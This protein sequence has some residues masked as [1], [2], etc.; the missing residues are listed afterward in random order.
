MR[1]C[2]Q[3]QSCFPDTVERCAVDGQASKPTLP[4]ETVIQGRYHLQKR[5][6]QGSVGIVYLTHDVV[7]DKTVAV[8]IVL[9]NLIGNNAKIGKAILREATAT[10]A[11]KHPN[12]VAVFDSGI[13][14]GLLPFVVF[15][16]LSAPTLENILAGGRAF[17]PS[18]AFEYVSA[19]GAGLAAAH[20]LGIAHGDLKPRSILVVENRPLQEAIKIL[21]F[22]MSGIKSGKLNDS[23]AAPKLS[24]M[25]RS[26]LYLAP[27][28]WSDSEPDARSDIYGLGV[29]LYQMLAGEVPFKGK[30]IPAIMKQH[31][32]S[33]PPPLNGPSRSISAAVEAAV[34]HALEKEPENRPATIAAFIDELRASLDA[35]AAPT[36]LVGGPRKKALRTAPKATEKNSRHVRTQATNESTARDLEQTIVLSSLRAKRK[37]QSAEDEGSQ[38]HGQE[39]DWDRTIVHRSQPAECD[40]TLVPGMTRYPSVTASEVPVEVSPPER[41]VEVS[42]AEVAVSDFEEIL[43]TGEL[44]FVHETTADEEEPPPKSVSPGLLATG[45]ILVILLVAF[46]IFYSRMSQ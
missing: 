32:I 25:L 4:I 45:V 33:P 24:N 13:L 27:E 12:I 44:D 26:P 22:G 36:R 40:L 21:D 28:A 19:I 16:F 46:G 18:E 20:N 31:L 41:S 23:L 8:K 42:P 37:K 1:E 10:A 43:E 6:G 11:V 7:L 34:L 3:C 9:P 38:A 14:D 2:P 35:V 29:I 17:A 5:I 30:S 39:P 15:E